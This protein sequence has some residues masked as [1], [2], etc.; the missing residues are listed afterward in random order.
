MAELTPG[1][2]VRQ[3]RVEIG[4]SRER[5]AREVDLST[6]TIVRLE[7]GDKLPNALALR[8]ISSRLELSIDDLVTDPAQAARSAS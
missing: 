1:Q 6:S 3:R 2:I 5:L 7:L 8:R 4:L